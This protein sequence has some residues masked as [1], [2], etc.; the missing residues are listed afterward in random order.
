MSIIEINHNNI[1]PKNEN[2]WD[3]MVKIHIN[4]AVNIYNVFKDKIKDYN[5]ID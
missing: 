4:D 2:N 5:D 3:D 1:D